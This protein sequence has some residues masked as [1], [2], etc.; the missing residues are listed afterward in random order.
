MT[1]GIA[2]TE[3]QCIG[4]AEALGLDPVIKRV[5]LKAPW[6]QLSPWLRWGHDYA[7]SEDSAPI[8]PPWPDLLIASGRKSILTALY[9]KKK[10]KKTIIVQLQDPRIDPDRFDLVAVPQ[11]DSLRG[12]NV[13]VTTGAPHRVTKEKLASARAEWLEKFKTMREPRVAVLVGGSTRGHTMTTASV[14]LLARQLNVIKD[15]CGLMITTS[16]RTGKE[17]TSLLRARL[18]KSKNIFFWDG[19]GDNPYFGLL[20]LADHIIVTD[21]SV[22]MLSEALATGKPVHIAG[23][24]GHHRRH[25]LFHTLLSEQG[26]ARPFNGALESWHYTP[27][28]DTGKIAEEIK[29][30][31]ESFYPRHSKDTT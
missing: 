19:V 29:K 14:D 25:T 16:R 2:G 12:D 9:I 27:P 30:K 31:L 11:H 21:D 8:A 18:G 28:D 24:E 6:K 15:R 5:K 7:L 10:N 4:V 3:N 22:S 17:N 20:A 23:L 26:Y 1:E 13:L